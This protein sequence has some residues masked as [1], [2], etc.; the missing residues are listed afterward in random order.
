MGSS[1]FFFLYI[2]FFLKKKPTQVKKDI[3]FRSHHGKAVSSRKISAVAN[4][5]RI[6][7]YEKHELRSVGHNKWTIRGHT[8]GHWCAKSSGTLTVDD[9]K[10]VEA[11][12]EFTVHDLG[13]GKVALQG[14]HGKYVCAEEDNGKMVVDRD[15]M[16]AWE[17]FDSNFA[18]K[19]YV[20]VCFAWVL[21]VCLCVNC[22][23]DKDE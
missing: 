15:H 22:Y 18:V 13:H 20:S 16:Q 23:L 9:S 1:T 21:V 12:H 19:I 17:K 3:W 14:C 5:D 8:G 6:L 2:F 7:A 4:R 10:V 11:G